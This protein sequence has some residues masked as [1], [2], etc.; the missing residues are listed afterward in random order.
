MPCRALSSF[1]VG[2][3]AAVAQ[4]QPRVVVQEVHA[5]NRYSLQA[6]PDAKLAWL[7]G[8]VNDHIL[9]VI[10]PATAL[11]VRQF[12][13]PDRVEFAS[14][15]AVSGTVVAS[16]RKSIYLG[17]LTD[18]TLAE[19]LPGVSGAVLL[20]DGAKLLAVLGSVPD[21]KRK[22]AR[23]F[24]FLDER[25]LGVYDLAK[26]AW[27]HIQRTPIVSP[28]LQ[29]HRHEGHEGRAALLFHEQT[30]RAGG[31][32]G[33]L[34]SMIPLTFAADVQLDLKTGKAKITT[35]PST[36]FGKEVEIKLPQL[37]EPGSRP[38]EGYEGVEFK[39]DPK[40]AYP[41]SLLE[42]H[43][44][45]LVAIKKLRDDKIVE[46]L[47]LGA[48]IRDAGPMP[49]A[50]HDDG[51]RIAL[52][53]YLRVAGAFGSH[54]SVLSLTR[55]GKLELGPTRVTSNNPFGRGNM[56][57][58]R[59]HYTGAELNDLITGQP[60]LPAKVLAAKGDKDAFFLQE[61]G[62]LVDH[63]EGWSLY[64]PGRDAPEWT[65]KGP[66][67]KWV[68]AQMDEEHK[69]VALICG[70]EPILAECLSLADGAV[71]GRVPRAKDITDNYM[72]MAL[73]RDGKRLGVMKSGLRKDNELRV[74]DVAAGKMLEAHALPD[75]AYFRGVQNWSG[76]WLVSSEERSRL[77]DDRAKKFTT[78]IPFHSVIKLH[79]VE[80]PKGKRFIL[81]SSNGQCCLVDPATGG[82]VSQWVAAEYGQYRAPLWN[83]V[84]A[85]GKAL[86]RPAGWTAALEVVNLRDS[87]VVLT[88]HN[89]PTDMGL[90]FIAFTP[91]GLW[92][93]TPG[94]ERHVAVLHKGMRI[95]EKARD[96]RRN[97]KVI[98]ERLAALWR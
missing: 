53:R 88:I 80:T 30:L 38:P 89:V 51:V 20:D 6:T 93:A 3:W 22:D 17:K 57:S 79:E 23:R 77:F 72:S 70:E 27:R 54:T 43:E 37:K 83:A 73:S 1:M 64:K 74:F 82:I 29:A 48:P 31:V 13:L 86:L 14:V 12:Y 36:R 76:G 58:Y 94:A 26:K 9:Q 44:A 56:L 42:A 33:S 2:L 87:S 11:V 4:A 15:D 85:G 16:T 92:D 8:G 75:E 50:V 7:L 25:T 67:H 46:R 65:Y 91:D 95:D 47:Q 66:R 68:E 69:T 5:G 98:Q 59:I 40:Y 24:S 41:V 84:F 60:L 28:S 49:F 35:G 39:H 63:A 71:I 34:G 61:A 62:T 21:P 55:D 96:K 97:A 52:R 32:G 90:G 18:D 81:Q 10:E 45:A 78:V 19:V